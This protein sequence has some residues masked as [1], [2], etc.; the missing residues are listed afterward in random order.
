MKS[1]VLS[2]VNK[3]TDI[4][5]SHYKWGMKLSPELRQLLLDEIAEL[6]QAEPETERRDLPPKDISDS[7][8][9]LLWLRS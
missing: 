9:F 7:Q 5:L 2:M 4:E 3:D 8:L 1:W 6:N